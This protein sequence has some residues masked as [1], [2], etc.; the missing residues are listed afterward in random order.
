MNSMSGRQIAQRKE[1]VW[2]L[3]PLPRGPP[4][5]RLRSAGVTSAVLLDKNPTNLN[6]QAPLGAASTVEK[7]TRLNCS[8]GLPLRSTFI[9]IIAPCQDERKKAATSSASRSSRI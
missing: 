8:I 5:S 9:R 7:S 3:L 4:G 6:L 1:K 2:F